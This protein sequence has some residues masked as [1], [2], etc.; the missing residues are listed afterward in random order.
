M[1]GLGDEARERTATVPLRM[2][3]GA[4]TGLLLVG[5]IG[6]L[7]WMLTVGPERGAAGLLLVV[8]VLGGAAV[9]LAFRSE[10]AVPELRWIERA[11]FGSV[12]TYLG[13]SAWA[14]LADGVAAADAAA[15]SSRWNLTLIQFVLLMMAYGTLVPNAWPRA[16]RHVLALAVLPVG[17]VALALDRFQASPDLAAVL[18][19][20]RVV[21][22]LLVLAV[23][24]LLAIGAAHVMDQY[25][26]LAR[27]TR[28]TLRYMLKRRI[29][30][31][32]MGEVWLGEHNLLARPAAIKLIRGDAIAGKTPEQAA[33]MLRRFEREAQATA[34]LRSPHTVEVYDYGSAEDGTFYYAMEYLVGVDFRTLVSDHGPVPPGRVVHLLVQACESLADAHAAGLL[35]RDIKPANLFACHLGTVYD[36]VKVLDFGLVTSASLPSLRGEDITELTI[37][38][39]INGTPGYMAPELVHGDVEPDARA[40][41]YA[42]G[43]V[44]YY[45]LAGQPV[46][47]GPPL[48][49]LVEHVKSAPPRLSE[50]VDAV[51]E[52][53][54][55]VIMRCLAKDPAD[56]YGSA[57]A[58]SDALHA[59]CVEP[60]WGAAEAEAW[61]STHLSASVDLLERAPGSAGA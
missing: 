32:G 55:R 33:L 27:S 53:L 41:L 36:F 6:R 24:G 5:A 3:L 30:M 21:E 44:G 60:R 12:A 19:R 18:T 22:S 26:S 38:G 8:L 11:V 39:E 49:V 50:R 2:L 54:E 29:G 31:G 56:R 28:V 59:C 40:D 61:W 52:A 35:H 15:L 43:C 13:W 48:T 7:L 14:G 16:A 57:R 58:L 45:L 1:P 37:D 34:A 10:A 47:D 9:A 4:A 25:L 23:S 46:F 17:V 42:L 20:G 51:P